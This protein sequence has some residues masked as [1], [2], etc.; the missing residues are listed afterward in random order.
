M[1]HL[2]YD[3]TRAKHPG[4]CS[5]ELKQ[6]WRLEKSNLIDLVPVSLTV[7]IIQTNTKGSFLFI[8]FLRIKICERNGFMTFQERILA[9]TP[10]IEYAALTSKE[11]LKRI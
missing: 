10:D 6:I 9:R 5:N 7:K 8:F 11:V 1:V 2:H 3:I 4:S